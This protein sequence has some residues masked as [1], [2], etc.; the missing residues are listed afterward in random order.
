MYAPLEVIYAL[1]WVLRRKFRQLVQQKFDSDVDGYEALHKWSVENLGLF[2]SVCWDFVGM[3]GEKNSAALENEKDMVGSCFFPRSYVNLAENC[4]RPSKNTVACIFN[5]EGHASRTITRHELRGMVSILQQAFVAKGIQK[6]DRVCGVTANTPETIAVMLALASLGAIWSSVSPDFGASGVVERFEQVSPKMI[7]LADGYYVKGKWMGEEV[8]TTAREIVHLLGFDN[9]LDKVVVLPFKRSGAKRTRLPYQTLRAFLGGFKPR[10][11]EYAKTAFNDPVFIM[12]SSGTT[13][14]PKCI[15][16]KHGCLLQLMKEHQLHCDIR[17]GD[18]AFYYTTT[19]WMMWQW[20]TTMLASEATILL[21][22]GNPFCPNPAVLPKLC[23][24]HGVKFFGVS[25]KYIDALRKSLERDPKLFSQLNMDQV[26]MISSTGSP[27]VP[28]N[29]DFLYRHWPHICVSSI[30]GGTDIISTFMLGNPD[31]VVR[32]GQ[33]QCRGL[34]MAVEVWDDSG[35]PARPGATGELVCTKP[36]PSQPWGFW[37]DDAN[38]TKYREAYFN[39]EFGPNV[40]YHGDFCALYAEGGLAVFGRSDATLNPGGVRIGTADIYKVVE[41]MPEI[42]EALCCGV[43]RSGDVIIALFVVLHAGVT[44]DNDLRAKIRREIQKS[45]TR[46]HVPGII[47]QVTDIPRTK[48]GKIVEL[49]VREVLHHRKVRN[50][51]A[52]ANPQVLKEF[53]KFAI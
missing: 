53:E 41:H 9:D 46:H 18:K 48:N 16:H 43:S 36:F 15:V 23:K 50:V 3:I 44:L 42:T 30:S 35:R 28:E 7:F 27:L 5:G 12:F 37:G 38:K 14:K 51:S 10:R 4:L 19:A 25:A 34:G 13:G 6:G 22:D 24:K 47:E 33:I 8:A 40:W 20:L 49:A 11:V 21:Y 32:R 26:R 29:Y 17:P 1:N 52:L 45:C 2:W 39:S 31:G